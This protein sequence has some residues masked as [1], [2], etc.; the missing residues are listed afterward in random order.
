MKII[1]L[2]LLSVLISIQVVNA[3]QIS[4]F[5]EANRTGVS[6]ETGLLKSWPAEGPKLLWT[7]LELPKGN[8]SVSFGNNVMYT[9]GKVGADDVLFALDM[10]GKIQWQ[11]VMGRAW[12]Q[13]YPES[14]AT[15]TVEGNKVYTTSGYGD[16]ACIDVY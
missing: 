12:T 9:T 15:P 3:Q 2:I 7:N 16:I 14:R 13:S 4:E 6:S 10:N 8:S 5:R 11:T 1:K